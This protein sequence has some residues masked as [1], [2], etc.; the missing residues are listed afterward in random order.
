MPVARASVG[1]P[2]AY[3][4]SYCFVHR[5]RA[6]RAVSPRGWIDALPDQRDEMVVRFQRI[7][8]EF[9]D[10]FIVEGALKFQIRR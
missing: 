6:P 1:P 9:L 7:S 4:A 3:F 8:I 5:S 2:V 10:Y